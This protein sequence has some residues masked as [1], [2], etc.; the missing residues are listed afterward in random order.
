LNTLQRALR[1]ASDGL[2]PGST[3]T[4]LRTL[5]EAGWNW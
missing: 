2:P 1:Q 5:Q 3:W 4:I